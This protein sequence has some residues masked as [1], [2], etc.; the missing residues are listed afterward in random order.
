M[1]YPRI[2]TDNISPSEMAIYIS[3]FFQDFK[4]YS[5]RYY[6]FNIFHFNMFMATTCDLLFMSCTICIEKCVS[7][8]HRCRNSGNYLVKTEMYVFYQKHCTYHMLKSY[9]GL[10]KIIGDKLRATYGPCVSHCRFSLIYCCRLSKVIPYIYSLFHLHIRSSSH[11]TSS[12][13]C[14]PF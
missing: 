7:C 9:Q 14:L 12:L 10:H 13:F 4:F 3:E 11:N 2:N 1:V 8:Y 6:Y 5:I